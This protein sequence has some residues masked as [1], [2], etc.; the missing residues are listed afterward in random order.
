M[1]EVRKITKTEAKDMVSNYRGGRFF[2]VTFTKRSDGSVRVMNCRKGVQKDLSG[3]GPRYDPISRGL[4]CVRDVQIREH[5]MISLENIQE[6][7]MDG[8]KF[9]VIS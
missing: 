5:R 2:T 4:V 8:K 3:N 1:N 6:I 7:R 9:Q